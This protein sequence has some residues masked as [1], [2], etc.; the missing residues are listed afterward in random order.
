MGECPVCGE[1][2][3]P[4][5]GVFGYLC[6]NSHQTYPVGFGPAHLPTVA[7]IEQNMKKMGGANPSPKR[8]NK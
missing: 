3:F 1:I 8:R 2:R 7:E 6:K 4:I 5:P